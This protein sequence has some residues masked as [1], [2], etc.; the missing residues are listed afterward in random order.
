MIPDGWHPGRTVSQSR[1]PA[2]FHT[3]RLPSLF[4][5]PR[6][7]PCRTASPA[8]PYTLPSQSRS[9]RTHTGHASQ[10][11]AI[12]YPV[13]V[14]ASAKIQS[15]IIFPDP[16]TDQ[17]PG[18][19]IHRRPFHR[20]DLSG[21]DRLPVRPGI[22]ICINPYFLLQHISCSVSVKIKVAVIG[23]IKDGVLIR[24]A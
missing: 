1:L 20:Y 11:A 3:R 13:M 17:L 19:E 8:D 23:K 14:I 4:H 5:L 16:G 7:W 10:A 22:C 2:V 9:G 21:R 6:N 15:L 24:H 18:P 12:Q